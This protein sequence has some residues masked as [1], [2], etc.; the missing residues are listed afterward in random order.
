[1]CAVEF[2]MDFYITIFLSSDLCVKDLQNQFQT[3]LRAVLVSYSAACRSLK[4]VNYFCL[5]R[6]RTLILKRFSLP[7]QVRIC[8]NWIK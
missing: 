1:M 5:A 8:S 2:E 4:T 3:S 6:F 7:L